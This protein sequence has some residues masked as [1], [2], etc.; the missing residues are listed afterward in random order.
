MKINKPLTKEQAKQGD[1]IPPGN[2]D[3]V[4]IDA[5]DKIS[6]AGNDMI[7]VKLRI[8]MPNGSE[9]IMFDYLLESLEYK[10]AHFF[11]CV[12]LWKEYESGEV[13]AH[14]CVG[15]SGELKTY[16]QKGKDGYADKHA[17]ADYLLTDE[18]QEKKDQRKANI[19]AKTDFK[20][21]DLPF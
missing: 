2:Y 17:V 14:D 12:D 5:T 10:I 6:K 20:E 18:Q 8:Y 3:F 13:S 1:L 16:I 7:E 9:R 4:V 15:K 21:D 19:E 11:Q